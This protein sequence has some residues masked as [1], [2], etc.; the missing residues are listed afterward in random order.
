MIA[1]YESPLWVKYDCPAG[2]KH[3]REKGQIGSDKNKKTIQ[4][5][6]QM[7]QNMKIF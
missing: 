1:P 3:V 4:K 6:Q 2:T 7:P 5:P